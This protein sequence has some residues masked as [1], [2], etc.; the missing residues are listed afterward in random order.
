MVVGNASISKPPTHPTDR[1]VEERWN[2]LWHGDGRVINN[3]STVVFPTNIAA[4]GNTIYFQA[5]DG[6]NGYELWKSDG[7][8]NLGTVMVKDIKSGSGFKS[9]RFHSR[10]RVI[11]SEPTTEPRIIELW[12]CEEQPR[13]RDGQGFIIDGIV[14]A[15]APD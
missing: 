11:I 8:A 14:I 15:V 5:I 6:T 13:A 9:H 4:F 12:T 7:T 2:L 10:W 1:K 3:G